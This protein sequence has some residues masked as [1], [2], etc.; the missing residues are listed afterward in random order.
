VDT[1]FPRDIAKK[2]HFYLKPAPGDFHRFEK[3]FPELKHNSSGK[4]RKAKASRTPEYLSANFSK[5]LSGFG[6]IAEAKS[7]LNIVTVFEFSC[8]PF[9]QIPWKKSLSPAEP[10]FNYSRIRQLSI[11]PRPAGGLN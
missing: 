11:N 8:P 7:D 3:Q 9:W 1:V 2:K 4:P 5:S 10:I 6:K